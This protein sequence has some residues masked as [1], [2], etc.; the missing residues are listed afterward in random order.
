VATYMPARANSWS[1]DEMGTSV[2]T[3]LTVKHEDS[4]LQFLTVAGI[5]DQIPTGLRYGTT[6]RRTRFAILLH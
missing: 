2:R 6:P 1:F 3:P 5:P 4:E